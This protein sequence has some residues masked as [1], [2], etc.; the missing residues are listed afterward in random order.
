LLNKLYENRNND[1]QSN[2][3]LVVLEKISKFNPKIII[4]GGAN[5]EDYSLIINKIGSLT[6]LVEDDYSAQF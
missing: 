2:G 6:I 3:E 5:I 1:I 4:D